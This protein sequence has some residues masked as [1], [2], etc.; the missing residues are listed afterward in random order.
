M[1][2]PRQPLN[3]YFVMLLASAILMLVACIFMFIE[4]YRYGSPWDFP[5][6]PPRAMNPIASQSS[7]SA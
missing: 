7:Q 4:A 2:R 3:V 1:N 5:K 6:I